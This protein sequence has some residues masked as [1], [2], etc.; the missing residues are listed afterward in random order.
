M[1]M[2]VVDP[3]GSGQCVRPEGLERSF[4]GVKEEGAM[5]AEHA[6]LRIVD[7]AGGIIGA[8]LEKDSHFE[9]AER[10]A[11]QEPIYVVVS[12]AGSD[13]MEAETSAL[14]DEVIQHC[15]R[16]GLGLGGAGG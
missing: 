3:I 5:Q 10:L 16:A 12:V 15:S 7:Q 4:L 13:D 8:H 9:L 2:N 1:L 14:T 6:G 11:A